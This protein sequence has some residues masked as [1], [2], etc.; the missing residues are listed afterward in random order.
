MKPASEKIS[1]LSQGQK[2]QACGPSSNRWQ[3]MSRKYF[4]SAM[5]AALFAFVTHPAIAAVSAA[6]AK[7]S[8]DA[9]GR[10]E[11]APD[12]NDLLLPPANFVLHSALQ[13]NLTRRFARLPL[14]RGTYRGLTY[15]YVLT[16]VS[17]QALATQL[18]LNFAPKLANVPKNAPGAFQTLEVP[19]NILDASEVKFKG[20]PDFLPRR[21][22]VPGPNGFPLKGAEPGAVAGMGYSP[23]VQPAGTNVIYNAPIVAAGNGFFDVF[24]H[25]NTHDRVIGINRQEHTVDVL[26]I[27]AFSG[28]KEVIYLSFDATTPEA[29]ALERSTFTPGIA[30]TPFPNG[31]FRVDGARA[32]L[33]AFVNGQTGHQSPPAQGLNH[34]VIDGLITKEA[35]P[36]SFDVFQAL[37]NDGDARNVLEVF[38]TMLDPVLRNEY[39]PAWDLH[40]SQWRS[41]LVQSGQNVAQTDGFTIRTRAEQFDITS[42]GGFKLAAAGVEVNCPVIAF[43]TDPPLAPLV[44]APIPLP[45]P[46]VE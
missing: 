14:H 32:T 11:Q 2:K 19:R 34:L 7:Q 8:I 18:G 25:T 40:F 37:F 10:I 41:A 5:M 31:G 6:A 24:F 20:V 33:F 46:F 22:V 21:Q 36:F 28:G 42:L 45:L 23:Y 13:V 15:W 30:E 44:P 3:G 39:S 38:P 4:L 16:D 17:D 12:T 43:V 26:F 9:T 35:T 1:T 29:A 27:Q